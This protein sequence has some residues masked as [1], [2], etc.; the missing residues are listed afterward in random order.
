MLRNRALAKSAWRAKVVAVVQSAL[1]PAYWPCDASA[2]SATG[3]TTFVVAKLTREA[4]ASAPARAL[5]TVTLGTVAICA[6][7]TGTIA[8]RATS[9]GAAAAQIVLQTAGRAGQQKCYRSDHQQAI[10]CRFLPRVRRCWRQTTRQGRFG[11]VGVSFNAAHRAELR[12]KMV[13]A[14]LVA[15]M[16]RIIKTYSTIHTATPHQLHKLP[17]L[18]F[19]AGYSGRCPAAAF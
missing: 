3:A 2:P 13:S 1:L 9:L 17:S 18:K 11:W 12:P 4:S 16:Q 8:T 10:H 7:A 15:T 14:H 19:F 5:G 6:S